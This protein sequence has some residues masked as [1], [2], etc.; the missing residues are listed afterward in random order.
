MIIPIVDEATVTPAARARGEPRLSIAG[1]R[2]DPME[3]VSEVEDPEMPP[4]S[5]LAPTLTRP[6]P[7]ASRPTRARQNRIKRSVMP[8]A[9]IT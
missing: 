6:S 9:F 7:L 8:L 4:K 5:I 3:A 1:M 2:T